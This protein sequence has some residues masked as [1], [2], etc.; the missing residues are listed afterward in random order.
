MELKSCR[1][2]PNL[3]V[4]GLML[5]YLYTTKV[6]DS[7]TIKPYRR[8]LSLYITN[9]NILKDFNDSPYRPLNFYSFDDIG[10]IENFTEG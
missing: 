7:N 4:D 8:Y 9:N 2:G 5:F 6:D 1:S 10:P 3:N